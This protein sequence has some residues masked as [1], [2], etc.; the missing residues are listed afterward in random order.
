M[1]IMK[2]VG[3]TFTSIAMLA[4]SGCA[5][6]SRDN[7][8]CEDLC[9]HQSRAFVTTTQV[10][11]LV[12]STQQNIVGICWCAA[13]GISAKATD[14]EKAVTEVPP[15]PPVANRFN[16]PNWLDLGGE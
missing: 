3:A 2:K 8:T 1:K 9:R 14:D 11:A 4:S 6:I 12:N 5:L 10:P 13:P 15:V 16:I 7:C